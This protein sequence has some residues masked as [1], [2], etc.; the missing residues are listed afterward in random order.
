MPFHGE[1]LPHGN[2][3]MRQWEFLIGSVCLYN[4]HVKFVLCCL[5][6]LCRNEVVGRVVQIRGI[7]L[8]VIV[9]FS[10]IYEVEATDRRVVC[11]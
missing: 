11:G 6:A 7:V 1:G 8:H 4:L 10:G 9:G 5:S 2:G 3:S